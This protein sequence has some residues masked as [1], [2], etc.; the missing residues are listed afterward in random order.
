MRDFEKT[1]QIILDYKLNCTLIATAI[2]M[3]KSAFSEKLKGHK[4]SMKFTEP[5]KE[6]IDIWLEGLEKRLKG[7]IS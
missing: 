2:G 6:K 4:S 3:K 7:T 1:K 5:Q